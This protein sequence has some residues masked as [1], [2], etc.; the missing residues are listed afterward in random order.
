MCVC[1]CLTTWQGALVKKINICFKCEI[2]RKGEER[3]V[4]AVAWML[5]KWASLENG[6]PAPER[7]HH[8]EG[9]AAPVLRPMQLR[10][11]RAHRRGAWG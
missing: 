3:E 11:R 1:V 4:E 5:R 9:G 10:W 2:S 7:G 8:P 6:Q